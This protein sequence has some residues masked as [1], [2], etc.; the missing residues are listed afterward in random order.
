MNKK[1]F[2]NVL[3]FFFA[4]QKT[5]FH[6]S[7]HSFCSAFS[8]KFALELAKIIYDSFESMTLFEKISQNISKMRF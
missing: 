3:L 2:L 5:Y 6:N 4:N 8:N 1:G 7:I